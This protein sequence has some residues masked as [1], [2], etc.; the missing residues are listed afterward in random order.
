MNYNLTLKVK[1][2]LS[3]AKYVA[4]VYESLKG[5]KKLESFVL[6]Q[7]KLGGWTPE[8]VNNPTSMISLYSL[9]PSTTKRRRSL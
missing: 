2:G 4:V 9:S 3:T 5:E 8:D 6:I 7:Q 1:D